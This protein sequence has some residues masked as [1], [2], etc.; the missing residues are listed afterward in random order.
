MHI[1]W[2]E[3][4]IRQTCKALCQYLYLPLGGFFK[5]Q[6]WWISFPNHHSVRELNI[7][8]SMEN[9]HQYA[10]LTEEIM[11][12][13]QKKKKDA[14]LAQIKKEPCIVAIYMDYYDVKCYSTWTLSVIMLLSRM[15]KKKL[16]FSSINL[17][18]KCN[19]SSK[20]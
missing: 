1:H 9:Q 17:D 20:D 11:F 15:E 4:I 13:S 10:N 3:G 6:H 8:I 19:H 7:L 16:I 12:S 18:H 14:H 2:E 5:E